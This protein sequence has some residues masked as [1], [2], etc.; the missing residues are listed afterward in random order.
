MSEKSPKSIERAQPSERSDKAAEAERLAKTEREAPKLESRTESQRTARKEVESL[1]EQAERDQPLELLSDD[2]QAAQTVR[3]TNQ[4]KQRAFTHT[5]KHVQRRLSG[6]SRGFSRIIHNPAVENVSEALAGTVARPSGI[7]G[8]GLFATVGL[9]VMLYFARRNGFAL[10]GSELI[11]FL[12]AGW[13]AGLT[14]ELVWRKLI[15]RS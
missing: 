15:K 5:L 7:L 2:D 6:P 8:A 14:G 13:L 9:A 11:L 4:D 1:H 10:S 3:I 12:L